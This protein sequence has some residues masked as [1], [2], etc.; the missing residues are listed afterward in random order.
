[1]I[2]T[3]AVEFQYEVTSGNIRCV[4]IPNIAKEQLTAI[5]LKKTR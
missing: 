3:K 1:M 5:S 2:V 4:L